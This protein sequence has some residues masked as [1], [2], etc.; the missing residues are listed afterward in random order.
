MSSFLS[1]YCFT[2]SF[3]SFYSLRALHWLAF[4]ALPC[5]GFP[6]SAEEETSKPACEDT[7]EASVGE[8]RKLG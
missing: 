7:H 1:F 2:S 3:L 8:Y 5:P 4:A 6:Q